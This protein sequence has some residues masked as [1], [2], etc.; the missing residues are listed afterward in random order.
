MQKTIQKTN[1]STFVQYECRKI[2]LNVQNLIFPE[3][4]ID[5][6]SIANSNSL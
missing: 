1:L 3:K 6:W 5:L 4:K 2:P